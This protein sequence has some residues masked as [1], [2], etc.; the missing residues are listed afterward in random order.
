MPGSD[1]SIKSGCGQPVDCDGEWS[2]C[3]SCHYECKTPVLPD[4][5]LSAVG[6]DK[7]HDL[8]KQL[9]IDEPD[10]LEKL[11]D[12]ECDDCGWD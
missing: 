3:G 11:Q 10:L 8:E 9:D 4:L 5:H 2:G 6:P 1:F 12:P 7:L